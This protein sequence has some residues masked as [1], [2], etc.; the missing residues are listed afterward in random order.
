[1]FEVTLTRF[2]KLVERSTFKNFKAAAAYSA[3]MRLMG[4]TVEMSE[5]EIA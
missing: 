5:K 3:T 2:G 1:M 4:Y